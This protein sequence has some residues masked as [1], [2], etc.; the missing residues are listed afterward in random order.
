M[1]ASLYELVEGAGDVNAVRKEAHVIDLPVH[2]CPQE[3][4]E[5][6]KRNLIFNGAFYWVE[7]VNESQP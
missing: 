5:C 2:A 1:G 3:I 4:G 6:Q 7:D